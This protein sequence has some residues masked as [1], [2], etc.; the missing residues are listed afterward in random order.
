MSYRI[1]TLLC[2]TANAE[3]VLS[4]IQQANPA[5]YWQDN[6]QGDRSSFRLLVEESQLQ[7]VIDTLKETIAHLPQG[8]LIVELVD[9]VHPEP[10]HRA[11]VSEVSFFGGLSREELQSKANEGVAFNLNFMI[12]L[13]L[14]TVVAAIGL[15]EGDLAAVIGAMVIAPM[16]QPHIAF[17]LGASLGDFSLMKRA[18]QI[19]L[20][21][22]V[23][24]LG[25]AY[26]FGIFWPGEGSMN[27][28]LESR[29]TIEYSHLGLALAA[30]AAAVLSLISGV[31][32]ALVGVMV[33]VA[34][35]PPLVASGLLAGSGH[36][37]QAE[38]AL[39]LAFA[40]IVCINIASK[41][42][43]LLH[44]VRPS[45][46]NEK[47]RA[48]ITLLWSYGAWLVMFIA[49]IGIIYYKGSM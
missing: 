11:A 49:I 8:R 17:S 26:L 5:D 29:T 43:F 47:K 28:V 42:V 39:W 18:A 37:A 2:D 22:L 16:L 1:I 15:H 19:N 40:N 36:W 31:S 34:L 35:L 25:V 21:G 12:L 3:D 10:V 41:L 9:A 46:L 13:F 33:A 24:V 30:G 14:S 38:G 6:G 45:G 4:L 44:G 32:S 20:F 7:Q 27:P 23:F 48:T